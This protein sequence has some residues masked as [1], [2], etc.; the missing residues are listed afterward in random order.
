MQS[1]DLLGLQRDRGIA[2]T[3]ADIRM[4]AFSFREFTNLLDKGKRLP[5]IAKPEAP[6]DAVSF[7]WQLPVWGLRMKELSLLAREW[8]NSAA[9]GRTGFANKGFGHVAC[10]SCQPSAALTRANCESDVAISASQ[11]I[12]GT[13]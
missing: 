11:A 8:W 10:L 12:E 4:M 9:T 2:P 5:E 1:L 6:L 13:I 3:E 7:L